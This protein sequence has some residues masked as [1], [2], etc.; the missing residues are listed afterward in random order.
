MLQEMDTAILIYTAK[1]D[2]DVHIVMAPLSQDLPSHN[3]L[4]GSFIL[5]WNST[6]ADE[7]E[8]IRCR[9]PMRATRIRETCVPE[10]V[11][12]GQWIV[13]CINCINRS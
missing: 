1:K 11:N 6:S 13:L 4:N 9:P 5:P 12:A 8:E 2:S 7:A 10:A 3:D